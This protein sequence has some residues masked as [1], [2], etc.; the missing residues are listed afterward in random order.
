MS[1][2][3]P[4]ALQS[5]YKNWVLCTC[6]KDCQNSN[7]QIYF[8]KDAALLQISTVAVIYFMEFGYDA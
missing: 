2:E 3:K 6:V 5:P 1:K 8:M 7:W 4:S